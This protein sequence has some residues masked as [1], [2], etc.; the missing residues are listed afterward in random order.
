[1]IMKKILI[2]L[3]M[4]L[5]FGNAFA[6]LVTAEYVSNMME[7]KKAKYNEIV[8]KQLNGKG[9]SI[10]ENSV[11][12]INIPCIALTKNGFKTKSEINV[13]NFLSYFDWE[14]QELERSAIK[15]KG[16]LFKLTESYY[17]YWDGES[18]W[19]GSFI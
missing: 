9:A 18:I 12:I 15:D 4:L 14:S 1:M 16:L 11:E 19:H 2:I 6:Q 17:T 13:D 3:A 10:D 5:S 8:L 7:T